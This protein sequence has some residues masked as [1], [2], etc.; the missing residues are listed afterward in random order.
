MKFPQGTDLQSYLTTL[1]GENLAAGATTFSGSWIFRFPTQRNNGLLR[2]IYAR[3]QT[4][5]N[6]SSLFGRIDEDSFFQFGLESQPPGLLGTPINVDITA[7]AQ[8]DVSAQQGL[9][10]RPNMNLPLDLTPGIPVVPGMNYRIDTEC[11]FPAAGAAGLTI[12]FQFLLTVQWLDP[13]PG[14]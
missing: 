4:I 5:D 9:M 6:T 2:Q 11:Q 3:V 7:Y 10:F 13:S 8:G 14:Q 1:A 12:Y